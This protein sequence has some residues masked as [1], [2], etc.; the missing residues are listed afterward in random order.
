MA[1]N[2]GR[3][4]WRVAGLAAVSGLAVALTWSGGARADE[5]A[6]GSTGAPAGDVTAQPVGPA[7]LGGI[8]G[9]EGG[10]KDDGLKPFAEVSK[11]YEKVVSTAD[12][13]SYYGVWVDKKKNRV[14]AELPRGF[15]NQRQFI[16][17]TVSSGEEYAGLQAG[18]V[19]AYW[20]RVDNRLMLIEPNVGT[21]S[22][23]D[24]ESKSSV[25]RLFTDRVLLDV[26]IV[27]TGP[28]GQPVIDIGELLSSRA[29]A[30][31]GRSGNAR[32]ATIKTAKAFPQNVELE[33]EMPVGGAGTL[34][35]FHYSISGIPDSTGYKPREADERVGY[36]TTVY[37][38]LGKWDDQE[39]W[40][41]YINRWNLEKAD[42]SLKLSPP[43]KPIVFYI[44]HTTPV[45]YRR[46]VRDG[47]LQW[48]KAFEAVGIT[49][50]VEVYQQDETTKAHM[51]KDP[52][53]VRYN[54]VRWLA[55]DQGT[56]IGPS[57]VH[58]LTGEI[59]DADIILTDG[60]IRYFLRNWEETVPRLA[61][62]GAGPELLAFLDTNP[63]WDPRIRLAAPEQREYLIAQ[64]E[65]RGVLAYGG[66][67]IATQERG[68]LMGGGEYDGLIGRTSQVNGMCFASE[69]MGFDMAVL[70]MHLAM[71]AVDDEKKDEGKKEEG[72][73]DD[74]KKEEKEK[75]NLIDGIP[76]EFVGPLLANLVTHEV[77]HTLGLRHNF[78][79]SAA[80]SMAEINSEKAKGKIPN[81]SS[82]M[83]YVPININMEDGPIQGDW[84]TIG[85]GAYDMWA[86]E[87]GYTSGDTKK[88]LSR[89]GEPLLQ[90]QTDEDTMGPDPLARR[91]D[92]SSNPLDY[93]NSTMRVAKFHR[94]RLLDKFVKDG[95]SWSNARR[96]YD[97]TLAMQTRSISMMAN[98]VGGAFV[99][100]ARKGDPGANNPITPVP[101][102]QQRAA[103]KFVV[104]NAFSDDAFGITPELLSKLTVDKWLDDGGFN[105]AMQEPALNIHDRIAGIQATALTLVMNPTTLRRVLDNEMRVAGAQDMI[106][107]P[108][109]MD[110]VSKSIWGELENGDTRKFS[111]R[112]PMISSLRRNLQ[113]E[114]LERLI[115]LT[116]PRA[117]PGAASK[118]ISNLAL[119]KLRQIKER[120]DPI[121]KD[122]GDRL[123]PYT[124]AHLTEAS[125]R[126]EAVLAAQ[127]VYNR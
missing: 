127:Y 42:P 2:E 61:L 8:R 124:Q 53:D 125:K 65:K 66:H 89:A 86:I 119:L 81:T 97:M 7:A 58:P 67:A 71:T 94:G 98:W 87:Y 113:R 111:A 77:G 126:I 75:P 28:G 51:D 36:F 100:R 5:P 69:G 91:Y 50:A 24:Q 90:F 85:I 74:A 9:G 80:M 59:L 1:R 83:D 78:R 44:E 106:T 121:L 96:G 117:F 116:G 82:T 56:A 105:M 34:Q 18:E 112:E 14:L 55:N 37:R 62:D 27:S 48:N 122:R 13:E 79:G 63:Q 76:E 109:V 11:G 10:D 68:R 104:D 3:S 92:L 72:K 15:E 4:G 23:G 31:F 103:L 29:S 6:G 115:D 12:G 54:F 114:H 19:Y 26:P 25:K 30:F 33:F 16:A 39:K 46:W 70:R 64:R 40:V 110:T 45:R 43:K 57:R 84:A 118:P 60:W 21:R 93:A 22:T 101:A 123:D 108:E 120:I 38:D 73:K 49:G 52:E 17:L 102:E 88:V 107:L 32:L 41:R 20:K 99:T 47:I 95:Q 35:S